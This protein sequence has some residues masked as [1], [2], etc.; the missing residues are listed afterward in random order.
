MSDSASTQSSYDSD[1][2]RSSTGSDEDE[3][4]QVMYNLFTDSN[5]TNVVEALL[6][7]KKSVDRYTDSLQNVKKVVTTKPDKRAPVVLDKVPVKR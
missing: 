4:I 6:S 5:G 3:L 1:G 2:P 7:L